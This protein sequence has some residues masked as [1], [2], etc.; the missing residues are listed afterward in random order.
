MEGEFA[1]MIRGTVEALDLVQLLQLINENNGTGELRIWN[2]EINQ[3]FFFS[4]GNIL[5]STETGET[6]DAKEFEENLYELLFFERGSY[7]FRSQKTLKVKPGGGNLDTP[8]ILVEASRRKDEMER[9]F[10]LLPSTKAILLPAMKNTDERVQIQLTKIGVKTHLKFGKLSVDE[11]CTKS[12]KRFDILRELCNF[13]EEG[14]LKVL[15]VKQIE[16]QIA[17]RLSGKPRRSAFRL[18]EWM[19]EV[20]ELAHKAESFDHVLLRKKWLSVGGFSC[21]TP[22]P[23]ALHLLSRLL[24][25]KDDF[26]LTARG[27]NAAICVSVKDRL[28]HLHY[29]G[30]FECKGIIERVRDQGLMTGAQLA[31]AAEI[32]EHFNCKTEELLVDRGFL[33]VAD[34]L[35][36]RLDQFLDICFSIFTWRRPLIGIECEQVESQSFIADPD[37]RSL[38]LPFDGNLRQQ[39]RLGLM[40]WKLFRQ[41]VPSM[42]AIF[43]CAQPTPLGKARRAHDHLDGRRRVSD[44][45]AM[46]RATGQELLQFIYRALKDKRLRPLTFDEHMDLFRKGEKEKRPAEVIAAY[47]SALAFGHGDIKEDEANLKTVEKA[48]QEEGKLSGLVSVLEGELKHFNLAAIIQLLLRSGYN[49]TLRVTQPEQG[50]RIVHFVDGGLFVLFSPEHRGESLAPNEF[51]TESTEDLLVTL[52][53]AFNDDSPQ[54][55]EEFKQTVQEEILEALFWEGASFE[56]ARNFIPSEFFN[57]SP[58]IKKIKLQDD[59]LLFEAM[60][61]MAE[62][63]QLREILRSTRAIFEFVSSEAKLQGYKEYGEFVYFID[64]H[65]SLGDLVKVSMVPRLTLYR[66]LH[67][68][69]DQELIVIKTMLPARQLNSSAERIPWDLSV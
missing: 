64:G 41:V 59:R 36:L 18:Y 28:L 16:A 13:C 66:D 49:G 35:K 53:R 48:K 55:L 46:S 22:G 4:N 10:R 17:T 68:M 57:E 6:V 23:R 56:F 43:K 69:I 26:E 33:D 21:R 2:G 50:E 7:I 47:E 32:A 1:P 40:R 60:K 12:G 30:N 14:V 3:K 51:L 39:L 27:S 25:Y 45:L 8:T 67:T 58:E 61:R 19:H 54:R 5:L 9:I 29:R 42:D 38:I 44:L 31:E 34:W 52:R 20:S 63:D 37:A 65:R 15:P 24:R 62:W 11:M